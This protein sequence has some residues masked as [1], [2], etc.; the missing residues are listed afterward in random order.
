MRAK[1][2]WRGSGK[3]DTRRRSGKADPGRA[4]GSLGRTSAAPSSIPLPASPRTEERVG[5]TGSRGF[6]M[7]PQRWHPITVVMLRS[8]EERQEALALLEG[9]DS[10]KGA[11]TGGRPRGRPAQRQRETWKSEEKRTRRRIL[12][13]GKK[14]RHSTEEIKYQ[15]F[16]TL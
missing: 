6:V 9:R 5:N 15:I 13:V 3:E 1:N 7:D 4:G 11:S 14:S 10:H 16:E 8:L 2:T 12:K